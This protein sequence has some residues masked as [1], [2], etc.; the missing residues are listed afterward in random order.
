M[1]NKSISDCFNLIPRCQHHLLLR[2][3]HHSASLTRR[4]MI[5]SQICSSYIKHNRKKKQMIV[6]IEYT[7][8]LKQ[9]AEVSSEE[10]TLP[11]GATAKDAILQVAAEQNEAL[12]KILLSEDNT[13]SPSLLFFIDD[14]QVVD[15][16]SF[17]MTAGDRITMMSPISGG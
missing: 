11:K 1:E 8:Q 7:A 3:Q 5:F 16:E 17:T 13:I 10:V 14:Q 4:A 9:A 15:L 2:Y 6:T 12:K